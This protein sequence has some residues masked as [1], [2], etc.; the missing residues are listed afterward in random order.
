M[1]VHS[2]SAENWTSPLPLFETEAGNK[3][4]PMD[5]LAGRLKLLCRWDQGS[6]RPSS[7]PKKASLRATQP[8][9]GRPIQR[10]D[11]M[12]ISRLSAC[13]WATKIATAR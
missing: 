8:A 6:L 7:L 5:S 2:V 3:A 4:K 1:F 13:L 12:G 10:T 11:H 9:G